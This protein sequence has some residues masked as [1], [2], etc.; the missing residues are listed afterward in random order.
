MKEIGNLIIAVKLK[1][2]K[3]GAHGFSGTRE[4]DME[5][6]HDLSPGVPGYNALWWNGSCIKNH[7]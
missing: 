3:S 1:L 7:W 6:S 2:G 4:S 5:R